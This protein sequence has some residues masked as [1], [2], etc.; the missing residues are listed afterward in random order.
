MKKKIKIAPSLLAANFA[1]L[2]EEITAVEDAGAEYLHLDVMDGHFVPN[3]SFGASL[4]KSIRPY[5][6]LI[7]DVHLMIDNP[8]RYISDFVDAGADIICVHAES[9]KHLNRTIQ[10]IKSYNVK[11]G[12]ALNPST[13]LD[14]IKYDIDNIDMILIMTVNPGFGGQKFIPQMLNKINDLRIMSPN[15][16]IQVDGG[17]NNEISKLVINAGA[18]ILVAGSYV[19]NGNYKEKIDSLRS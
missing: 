18:N 17:I 19:F 11:V 9:T 5:S 8:D 6:N 7:F 10:L 2:K 1:L 13:S 16:D 3:I 14:T 4:I 15:I 12:V